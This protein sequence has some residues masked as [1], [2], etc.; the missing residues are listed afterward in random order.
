MSWITMLDETY[1]N[2]KKQNGDGLLAVAH[3]EQNAHIEIILNEDSVMIGANFVARE[4]AVTLIPVTEASASRSSGITPHP[5][6]DK[7]Q[8]LA[9]DYED[10]T[11]KKGIKHHSAYMEQLGKWKESSY[12]NKKVEIIYD[13]LIKGN[14]IEDLVRFKILSLEANGKLADKFDAGDIKLSV[15]KQLDSFIRFRVIT[16]EDDEETVWEDEKLRKDYTE[17]YLSQQE[18]VGFCYVKGEMVAC[19]SNHPSKIR[20]SGDKAKIIS[21]NDTS[22]FTFKGRFK[23][24]QEAMTI[25]YQVSQKAHNALKWLIKNQGQK[26]GEKVFVLWG[27]EAQKTPEVFGD[28]FD[29]ID[30]FMEDYLDSE[31]VDITGIE[32]SKQFNQAILGYKNA[33]KPNTKLA[34]MGVEAA[35]TG[36]M[37]II[38]YREYNGLDGH[39]LMTNIENWHRTSSWNHRYKFK[40]KKNVAFNGA[41]SLRDIGTVAYGTDRGKSIEADAK[42][43]SNAVERLL[44]CVIDGSKI[45]KDI[46]IR[47]IERAKRPQNY[48]EVYTWLKVLTIGSAMYRKYL[49]DYK[50]E[51]YTMEVKETNNLA[52]NCGRLLAVA[53]AI[54]SWALRESSDGGSIRTTNAMRYFTR[55]SISP[56]K[57]WGI[58]NDKLNP[59]K[60]RLGAKG[61]KL[62]KLL[63]EISSL[64]DPEEFEKA[65]NLD[66]CMILGFDTQRQA[67]FN[68]SRKE[69][70]EEE[71]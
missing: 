59:Y 17:F 71:L 26:V 55:F 36:R 38:F 50:K 41:P 47:I 52:Y 60:Q 19:T 2:I 32:L 1:D 45:P 8:Y 18:E 6:C 65:V 24:A 31:E 56:C 39:E 34:L 23:T 62:Y 30:G 66:G 48:K 33:I 28:T 64:I 13:Y 9:G 69:K 14:L 11:D 54:E 15:G 4:N 49:Y 44:A 68:T 3:S 63:G 5:L 51:E 29:F 12:S 21:S 58:I 53:D 57:T 22:N 25:G 27:T 16:L 70:N 20:H 43:L 40:D 46:P 37:S 35:T 7:L 42:V 10:Y 61:G 67:L